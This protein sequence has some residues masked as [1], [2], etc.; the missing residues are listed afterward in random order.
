MKDRSMA[1]AVLFIS[2]SVLL[3]QQVSQVRQYSV[4]QDEGAVIVEVLAAGD[5]RALSIHGDTGVAIETLNGSRVREHRAKAGSAVK[6]T[7]GPDGR[8]Y[9][10]FLGQNGSVVSAYDRNGAELSSVN[11]PEMP[12]PQA[13]AVDSDG[14]LIVFGTDPTDG[15]RRGTHLLHRFDTTGRKF[16]QHMKGPLGPRTQACLIAAGDRQEVAVFRADEKRLY[17]LDR[18]G[19]SIYSVDIED[20]VTGLGFVGDRLFVLMAETEVR[21]GEPGV[22]VRGLKHSK[23]LVVER[24]GSNKVIHLPDEALGVNQVD[25]TGKLLRVFSGQVTVFTLDE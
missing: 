4:S 13:I 15:S 17:W 20:Y 1:V 18:N 2:G 11:Y 6:L 24:E 23:V 10:L 7:A 14:R 19:D 21:P 8:T 22:F 5:G 3:A 25:S 16:A 9:I 12:T